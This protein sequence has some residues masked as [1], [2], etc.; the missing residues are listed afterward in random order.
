MDEPEDHCLF[1]KAILKR[2][3]KIDIQF[4]TTELGHENVEEFIKKSVLGIHAKTTL[5][6]Q[7]ICNACYDNLNKLEDYLLKSKDIQQSLLDKYLHHQV[8]IKQESYEISSECQELLE[9]KKESNSTKSNEEVSKSIEPIKN[10]KEQKRKT[11]RRKSLSDDKTQPV[12]HRQSRA[13]KRKS[14]PK[15]ISDDDDDD[16]ADEANQDEKQKEQKHCCEICGK[17][18]NKGNAAKHMNIHT[19]KHLYVCEYCNKNFTQKVDLRRHLNI[20]MGKIRLPT[21]IIRNNNVIICRNISLC[22]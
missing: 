3:I 17:V 21:H 6:G 9:P 1:C 2:D 14:K 10:N 11:L 18:T 7:F 5:E 16:T 15:V 20:H 19:K 13:V 4:A 12:I 22:L 8:N